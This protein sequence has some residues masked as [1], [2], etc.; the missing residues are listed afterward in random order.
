MQTPPGTGDADLVARMQRDQLTRSETRRRHIES[1]FEAG[2]LGDEHMRVGLKA[3]DGICERWAL[4][5]EMAETILGATE[6]Q[7]KNI[8]PLLE[9]LSYLLRIQGLLDDVVQCDDQGKQRWLRRAMPA[10]DGQRPIDLLKTGPAGSAVVMEYLEA[11]RS[12]DFL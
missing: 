6:S 5:P 3:F 1:Q 11:C 8:A 7:E 4:G 9:R 10:F 12:G 2:V